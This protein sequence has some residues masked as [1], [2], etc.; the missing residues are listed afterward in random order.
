MQDYKNDLIPYHFF[1]ITK[2]NNNDATIFEKFAQKYN[3]SSRELAILTMLDCGS[4]TKTISTELY[5]SYHTVKTHIANIF[6]KVNVCSRAALLHK[7]RHEKHD[8]NIV[9]AG[10]DSAGSGLR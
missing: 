5:I 9:F 2:T 1:Y 8:D 4:N 3:L 6:R 10:S 7:L